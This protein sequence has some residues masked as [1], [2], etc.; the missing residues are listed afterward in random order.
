MG[1]ALAAAVLTNG[2][3]PAQTWNG[4]V[5]GNWNTA[6]N[7]SSLP[8]TNGTAVLTFGASSNTTMTQNLANPLN[9][10]GLTFNAGAPAYTLNGSQLNLIYTASN[11]VPYITQNSSSSLTINAPV[12]ADSGVVDFL[13]TGTGT[14]TISGVY[15]DGLYQQ[16][17]GTLVMSNSANMGGTWEVNK[18]TL[19]ITNP[20]AGPALSGVVTIDPGAVY[21]LGYTSGGNTSAPL[22]TLDL[23]GGT[24]KVP[25]GSADYYI[26]S[27]TT[28][29]SS[30]ILDFTGSTD[31]WL[32]FT[33]SNPSVV[34]A[35]NNTWIGANSSRIQNDATVPL[36]FNLNAGYVLN[37]GIILANGTNSQPILFNGNGTVILTN[38]A[39]TAN[40]IADAGAKIQVSNLAN[41]GS[42]TLTLQFLMNNGLDFG[43]SL[44]YTGP[45]ATLT[46]NITLAGS[47]GGYTGDG[48]IGVTQNGT[49]LTVSSVIGQTTAGQ[50]LGIFGTGTA[51]STGIVSLTGANTYTGPTFIF[52]GG[53]LNVSTLANG[54]T[55][56]PL[57][58]AT[59][60]AGNLL[61]GVQLAGPGTLLYTGANASTDRGITFSTTTADAG[62]I[63]V[64]SGT[65]L[66]LT[67][68][69][70][71]G[72]LNKNGLGT[73]TLSNSTSTFAE[74]NILAGTLA[75]SNPFAMGTGGTT[76]G[77]TV[78]VMAGAVFQLAYGIGSNNGTPLNTLNLNGGTFAA[79]VGVGG[80]YATAI[81]S[82]AGGVI[83]L[84]GS[85]VG[86]H[87]AGNMPAV[88]VLA[89]A[90]WLSTG[91]SIQN[92]T[93][94]PAPISISPGVTL[95]NAVSLAIGAYSQ[96][97]Q[98]IGGGTLN[99]T[100]IL[101]APL[102][103]TGATLQMATAA[104]LQPSLLSLDGGTFNYTGP[105]G[106]SIFP[107]S[108]TAN[109][110]TAIVSSAAA[111]L[112]VSGN[113][114]GTGLIDKQGPGTLA[115]SNAGTFAG[116]LLVDTGALQLQ[117][118]LG[119]TAPIAV[120][121]GGNLQY[122]ATQ[123]TG[124]TFNLNYGTLSATS[125]TT[126]TLSG[127]TVNGGFMRGPGTFALTG[128]TALNGVTV[129]SS[130]AISQT[131]TASFAN[132]SN[133]GPMTIAPGL[134]STMIGLTNQGSGS[135]TIGAGSQVN[136]SD[137]Q[138]Y[139]MLTLAPNTTSVPTI[140]T[141]T[142]SSP[143]YF[144]GGSQ[145]FLG[146]A[147]TA[148]PTGQTIVDY[149]DLHGNNAIV[150][151]GLFV[152][153]GG[154]FDTVGAGTGTVIAE[155]GALVKGAGFFQNTVKTQNGG[156]FQTGNSPGSATFGNFVFGPG[157][158]NNYIFAID[159]A[160][161]T[162]GPSPNAAGLVSGWGL[163]KAVQVSLGTGATSG[164]FT[165]TATPTDPLT[166][167]IDTLV[168][169]TMVGTD[170]A[171]PMA[172][173]DPNQSYSWTAARWTG[174]YAGPNDAATLDA[175]TTFDTSGF[176]NPIAGTFGWAVD[177]AD[178]MLS[179]VYTPTPVPE[180]GTFALVAFAAAAG[181]W[182]R[183]RKV[184]Q[185]P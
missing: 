144:N 122:G 120:N 58:A 150:A 80:Y 57:G 162:A 95:T 149:V 38:P 141:N 175:D 178:Q 2:L 105:S 72:M 16:T 136:A 172:D 111:T 145:T 63:Q 11:G 180:P 117:G 128:G 8:P 50:G 170:V 119:G 31:F 134:T 44:V 166:V 86:I 156:K 183:Q 135:I 181:W 185:T 159:D 35:G 26:N 22:G 103:I 137:F 157:G 87:L 99:Q 70:A 60:S 9:V 109:G 5:N 114:T 55:A 7:W 163:I 10:D 33:G 37:E 85:S 32:H 1:L 125:G 106:T 68:Q 123:T 155:Y 48:T 177:S 167:A 173:F 84:T 13:G 78:N 168:N 90:T 116:A 82:Q 107:L 18:G 39:N 65:N 59:N 46:K 64:V 131:G 129:E 154:V 15:T 27:I 118:S 182:G 36:N 176:A 148:D 45:S 97:F 139:G 41:L 51:A 75:I 110:G 6:G 184:S 4:S 130:A 66:T 146:T 21:Q 133:G 100:G 88:N 152:N 24:F 138:T 115:L 49:I 112:L 69:M 56:G 23:E 83:D 104:N 124:R 47:L 34:Y 28:Q 79:P 92:D 89:N 171:G 20:T 126:V 54:G 17:S 62:Y 14:I 67:G 101:Y 160:T 108:V 121:A 102:T 73:L 140:L 25:A 77:A 91:G 161:G 127:A 76:T 96:G 43:G 52:G 19:S 143:L 93:F 40:L 147:A 151:G 81:T 3:A 42:G 71:G 142:G 169:P 165:W 53:I 12:V 174:S 61:L 30:G 74:A 98:V 158:V 132:V 94:A 113:V 153:N 164:N 179:L 29:T